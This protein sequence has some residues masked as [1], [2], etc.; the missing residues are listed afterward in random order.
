MRL[1]DSIFVYFFSYLRC[2]NFRTCPGTARVE[3]D[4][5]DDLLLMQPHNHNCSVDPDAELIARFRQALQDALVAN[6]YGLKQLYDAM[7]LV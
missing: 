7:A 3:I 1:D 2:S 6:W 4:N 5:P